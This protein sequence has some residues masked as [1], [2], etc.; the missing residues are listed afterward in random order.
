MGG[1]S[2]CTVGDAKKYIS[3]SNGEWERAHLGAWDVSD[4][5]VGHFSS[6]F[7][8]AWVRHEGLILNLIAD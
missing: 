7:L 3:F 2:S 1:S 4:D 8:N 5:K 6:L